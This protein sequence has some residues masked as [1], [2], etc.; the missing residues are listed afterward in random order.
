[1]RK[2]YND[3]KKPEKSTVMRI[4]VLLL[5]TVIVLGIIITPFL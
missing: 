3:F 2:K 1:M 4:L 5:V